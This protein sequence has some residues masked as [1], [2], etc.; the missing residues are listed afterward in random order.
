MQQDK[1]LV[2]NPKVFGRGEAVRQAFFWAGGI[3]NSPLD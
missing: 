3:T 1:K 2:P